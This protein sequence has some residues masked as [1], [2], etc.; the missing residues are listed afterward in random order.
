MS[1]CKPSAQLHRSV[2]KIYSTV[3][4]LIDDDDDIDAS[5]TRAFCWKLV[6]KAEPEL[7]LTD[8]I[9]SEDPAVIQLHY[10]MD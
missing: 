10:K 5:Q 9:F 4:N 8:I 3:Y 7:T 1:K 6:A 2:A